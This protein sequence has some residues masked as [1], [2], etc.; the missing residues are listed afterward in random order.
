MVIAVNFF[1]LLLRL[2]QTNGNQSKEPKE[3]EVVKEREKHYLYFKK[4][5]VK[6]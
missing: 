5:S 4:F 3:K 2:F 1:L 6:R